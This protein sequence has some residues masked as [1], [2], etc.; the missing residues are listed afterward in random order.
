[1]LRVTVYLTV[2][3]FG[4]L[5]EEVAKSDASHELHCILSYPGLRSKILSQMTTRVIENAFLQL[6]NIMVFIMLYKSKAFVGKQ[7]FKK[8]TQVFMCENIVQT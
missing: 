2:P 7:T 6:S 8:H 1:M 4:R 5:K 3:A